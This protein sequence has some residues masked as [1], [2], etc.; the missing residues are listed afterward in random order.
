M[1]MHD[2]STPA[3]RMQPILHVMRVR[4]RHWVGDGF[5][6]STVFSP[7]QI[8]PQII[9]PFLLL[10]YGA[11]KEWQP[12]AGK[13]GVGEHPHRGFETVTFAYQGAVEHRD[14]H[15]GG[16]IIKAGDVQWMTAGSG[17]VHEEMHAK[18]F[19]Q[20]GGLFEMVQLWV[21][22]PSH[23]KMVDP[24]YQALKDESFPRLTLGSTQARLIAGDL[25]GVDGP[26]LTYSPVTM[27]DLEFV[28]SGST[29][30]VLADHTTTLIFVLRGRVTAQGA[31]AVEAGDLMVMDRS[32]PGRIHLE[33]DAG[34]RL[35]VLNG[36]P[37]NEPVVTHGPFVM[38]TRAQI[39]EA[40]H[41]YQSGKMGTLTPRP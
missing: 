13:R 28:R 39:I 25:A 36:Q 10:D 30:F 1:S 26:A 41:D 29:D 24:R 2:N 11:P 23:L 34:T 35:L 8:D 21:N 5:F 17:V 20:E 14:S 37:L 32:R 18:D 7:H 9:S 19:T 3:R 31:Y 16:G 33:S 15:G 6:V 40:I 22:L 4:E 12:G 27:F 38:N